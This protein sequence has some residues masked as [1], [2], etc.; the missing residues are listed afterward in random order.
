[1]QELTLIQPGPILERSAAEHRAEGSAGVRMESRAEFEALLAECGP[2]AYR[3][4]RGVLRNSADAEDVAQEAMLRAYRRFDHLRDRARF[5]RW[6]VRIAFRLA[7]GERAQNENRREAREMR[8][9]QSSPP[10]A[11]STD[12]MVS[13]ELHSRL[14]AALEEISPKYRIVLLLCAMEGHTLEEVAAILGVPLGTVKSRLFAGR[15]QLVEKLRW[16]VNT[17][18]P[19]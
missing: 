1:M 12:A 13:R 17:K 2:L 10:Q 14:D 8:W 7:R 16:Y 4:A 18:N 11:N 3:V 9:L 15:K 6:L 19:R 5:R